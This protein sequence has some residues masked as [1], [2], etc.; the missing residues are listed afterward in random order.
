[1]AEKI[2]L[3]VSVTA[4]LR[5]VENRYWSV[6]CPSLGVATQGDTAE[7]AR[8]RIAEAVELWFES[9]IERGVLDQ[10]L[11][12]CNF[13]PSQSGSRTSRNGS[14]KGGDEHSVLGDR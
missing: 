12:E 4:Y 13:R 11:R 7:Q 8:R 3:D 9:C 2:D 5:Q 14:R 1:M 10:A 6:V